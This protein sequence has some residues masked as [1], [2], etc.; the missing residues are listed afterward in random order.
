MKNNLIFLSITL[1][2]SFNAFSESE[3]SDKLLRCLKE[4]NS[5]LNSENDDK[6]IIAALSC[7][8]SFVKTVEKKTELKRAEILKSSTH[9]Y[10]Q[11]NGS[12]FFQSLAYPGLTNLNYNS[13][14]F[15]SNISSSSLTLYPDIDYQLPSLL[16]SEDDGADN[17]YY[18]SGIFGAGNASGHT[19]NT[20]LG[21]QSLYDL[22]S[23]DR[24]TAIGF[25]SLN[26]Q[27][28]GNN[29]TAIGE[30]SLF[31][32]TSAHSNTATG[33]RSLFSNETGH[34]NTASGYYSLYD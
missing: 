8:T 26:N 18:G 27:T 15:Q 29:N 19:D 28:S 3:A 4:Q 2:L 16:G 31:N 12:I 5:S 32:N 23:G 14:L 1:F 34:S 24:N 13:V 10:F 33:A 7:V 20:A 11:D 17:V 22:T 30:Q 25:K 21:F 9:R 6:A